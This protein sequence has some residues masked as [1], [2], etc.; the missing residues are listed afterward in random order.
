MMST[1]A[2]SELRVRVSVCVC[3]CDSVS[4]ER[5][6]VFALSVRIV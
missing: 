3:V 2:S 5:V 6:C 1:P 4:R